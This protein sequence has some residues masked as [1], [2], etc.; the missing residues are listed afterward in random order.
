MVLRSLELRNFRAFRHFSME[1]L[2][3]INLCVGTNNCGK[4]SVLEAVSI[5]ASRG[6]PE[7]LWSSLA[8]RGE[9]WN[10]DNPRL[11][12]RVEVDFC[13][14]FHG[15][16]LEAGSSFAIAATNDTRRHS[17]TATIVERANDADNAEVDAQERLSTAQASLFVSGEADSSLIGR[18]AL[19]L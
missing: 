16:E 1:G 17:L 7:A 11:P 14:L 2:G 3:R 8:R 5:L 10:D 19:A 12:L 6:R 15:H 18:A 9:Y 4:T 13:H